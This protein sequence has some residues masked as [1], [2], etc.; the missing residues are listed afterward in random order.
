M[1]KRFTAEG[2][3]KI[4]QAWKESGETKASFCRR[5]NI[6][7]STFSYQVKRRNNKES[8]SGFTRLPVPVV[9]KKEIEKKQLIEIRTGYCT[10]FLNGENIEDSLHAVLK[11]LKALK[12]NDI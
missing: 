4:L 11:T 1:S 2:W 8:V 5:N 3:E 12:A 10:I 6:S 7:L 9:N